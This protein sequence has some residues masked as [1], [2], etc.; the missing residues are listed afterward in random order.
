FANRNQ[1][2]A[3]R[4]HKVSEVVDRRRLQYVSVFHLPPALS[5]QRKRR[6]TH[7]T[8]QKKPARRR[9]SR[10]SLHHRQTI[11]TN[12][13]L[14]RQKRNRPARNA[15]TIGIVLMKKEKVFWSQ[16]YQ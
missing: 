3:Q 14:F 6:S 16:M 2:A 13:T 4:C 15:P 1:K 9:K 8:R 10:H 7:Q 11:R 5:Q 12:G